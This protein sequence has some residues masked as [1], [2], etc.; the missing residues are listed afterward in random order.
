MSFS[1]LSLYAGFALLC[2]AVILF[3]T[4]SRKSLLGE[5]DFEE[6]ESESLPF[7]LMREASTAR[8]DETGALAYTFEAINL[9]HFRYEL[10][11]IERVYT[12]VSEPEI[13]VYRD[14]TPWKVRS[15]KGRLE[16]DQIELSGDVSVHQQNEDGSE[17]RIDTQ[18]MVL[19]P[20]EKVAQSEEAVTITLP[21]GTVSAVGMYA[22]IQQEH[23][24][25][26]SKV[27]GHY[28]P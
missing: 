4:D 3:F 5:L 7:A 20:L 19:L 28:E 6:D 27:R 10:E 11:G 24:H 2:I 18:A 15:R 17:T 14:G 25:L 13:T 12:T 21:Y 8:Y 22:D 16:G 1:K 9:Q 23:I 26:K